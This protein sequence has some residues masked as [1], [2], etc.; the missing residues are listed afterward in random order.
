MENLFEGTGPALSVDDLKNF[1]SQIGGALP[2]DFIDFYIKFN[3]GQPQLDWVPGSD[4]WEPTI[5]QEFYPI[6]PGNNSSLMEDM[7]SHYEQF[8]SRHLISR[9]TLPFAVDPGGNFYVL[10][11]TTYEVKYL[12]TEGEFSS[13]TI[14]KSFG[15]FIASLTDEDSVYD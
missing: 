8:I 6:A 14:S 4:E 7:Y 3:G 1:E 11:L 2:A 10:D 12:L 15:D 5:I 13:R 9:N